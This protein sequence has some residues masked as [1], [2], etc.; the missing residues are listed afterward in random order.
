MLLSI[1]KR[2]GAGMPTQADGNLVCAWNAGHRRCQSPQQWRQQWLL[3]L[4]AQVAYGATPLEF[5]LG[6]TNSSSY[7]SNSTPMHR[8]GAEQLGMPLSAPILSLNPSET[9]ALLY[10]IFEG[11]LVGCALPGV[12]SAVCCASMV[13]EAAGTQWCCPLESSLWLN[14]L[15]Q[16]FNQIF[17][18]ELTCTCAALPRM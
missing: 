13:L 16:D 14:N 12:A 11:E 8:L 18:G 1:S 7:N 2:M 3:P 17:F 10:H 5:G 9:S 4:H 15:V 6:G